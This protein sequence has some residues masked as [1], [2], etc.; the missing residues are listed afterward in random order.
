MSDTP[1]PTAAEQ[2]APQGDPAATAAPTDA[3]PGDAAAPADDAA[4]LRAD[5]EHWKAMSRKNEQRAKENAAA[6][7]KLA[8]IEDAQKSEAEK[9]LAKL[10]DAENRAAAAE[11][12][13]IR[14]EVAQAKG[15]PADLLTGTTEDELNAAA[16]RLLAFRGPQQQAAVDYGRTT[17]QSP[18]APKQLTKADLKNMSPQEIVAADKAGLL[19]DVKAGRA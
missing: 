4:K 12:A 1:T 11:V 7:A 18:T 5:V 9:L 8:E 16:D 2:Q 14:A 10:Q 19:A 17:A 3:T 15:V 13:R 6:A